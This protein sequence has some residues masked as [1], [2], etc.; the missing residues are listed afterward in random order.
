MMLL[1]VLYFSN[2]K[3]HDKLVRRTFR[4]EDQEPLF[5]GDTPPPSSLEDPEAA[6]FRD[7]DMIGHRK[8]SGC[9]CESEQREVKSGEDI[10]RYEYGS[11]LSLAC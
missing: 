9:L 5:C 8:R 4:K 1:T 10:D 6:V 2:G 11:G 3:H 7:G